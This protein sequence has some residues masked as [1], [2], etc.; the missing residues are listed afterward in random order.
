MMKKRTFHFL[1]AFLFIP[2]CTSAFELYR[3]GARSAALGNAG[4]TFTGAGSLFLNPAGLAGADRLTFILS[5]ESRF[6]MKEMSVVAGGMVIP[7][8]AGTAGLSQIVFRAGVY[9][10]GRTTVAFA[11]RLGERISAAVG[12]DL[13]SERFPEQGR[14]SVALTAEAGLQVR[15][16]AQWPAALWVFHPMPF[17]ARRG[18]HS[19]PS[20]FRGG[21]S[22]RLNKELCLLTEVEYR[23]GQNPAIMTGLEIMPHPQLVFRAGFSSLPLTISGGAGIKVGKTEIDISFYQ[24]GC[25]GFTPVAGFTFNP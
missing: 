20:I 19:I 15:C 8:E 10:T 5:S 22:C 17:K 24:H 3:A 7:S 6:L 25:L 21:T 4:I 2:G 14:A 11:K 23:Q 9:H 16:H 12:F 13:L 18:N 1:F